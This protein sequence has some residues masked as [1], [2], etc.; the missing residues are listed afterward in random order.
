MCRRDGAVSEHDD[1]FF[2]VPWR[3][4]PLV[5]LDESGAV[6]RRRCLDSSWATVCLCLVLYVFVVAF[7]FLVCFCFSVCALVCVCVCVL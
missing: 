5:Q 6:V 1:V 3:Q 2:N 4:L 7:A